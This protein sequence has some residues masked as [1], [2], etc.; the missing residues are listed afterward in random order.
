MIA[1]SIQRS[2]GR[3]LR[4][5][6]LAAW[7]APKVGPQ[8][9]NSGLALRRTANRRVRWR[10][11]SRGENLVEEYGKVER[12]RNAKTPPIETDSPPCFTNTKVLTGLLWMT[13]QTLSVRGYRP[14]TDKLPASRR[15]LCVFCVVVGSFPGIYGFF[16]A[17]SYRAH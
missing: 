5:F 14:T 2:Q 12:L 15:S 7:E 11:V 13:N 16:Y 1:L 10:F 17:R 3:A 6:N 4:Q 8:V 9:G